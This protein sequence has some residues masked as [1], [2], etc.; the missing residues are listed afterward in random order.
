[1]PGTDA[2]V[3]RVHLPAAGT[4]RIDLVDASGTVVRTTA[5][6]E[7][8]V[9]F[10]HLREGVHHFVVAH[11]GAVEQVGGASVSSSMV[12]R[13]PSFTVGADGDVTVMLVDAG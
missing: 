4:G 11:E 3:A 12:V 8:V 2:V 5:G 7:P 6:D 9:H 13:S 1:V 10:A